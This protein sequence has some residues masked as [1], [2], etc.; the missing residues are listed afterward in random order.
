MTIFLNEAAASGWGSRSSLVCL[1]CFIKP[2]LGNRYGPEVV[3]QHKGPGVA[4]S[5]PYTL[6]MSLVTLVP[7]SSSN[8]PTTTPLTT[9]GFWPW[10]FRRVGRSKVRSASLVRF[11]SDG[12]ISWVQGPKVC[13][14]LHPPQLNQSNTCSFGKKKGGKKNPKER[15]PRWS[16]LRV[17][18][19]GF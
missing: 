3:P 1:F 16:H 17:T 11:L 10:R 2:I 7:S 6:T 15:H 5:S 8:G 9:R 14:I 18:E 4:G 13:V 12:K 19:P